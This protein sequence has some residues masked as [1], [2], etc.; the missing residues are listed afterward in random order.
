MMRTKQLVVSALAVL[1]VTAA[2]VGSA[3]PAIPT[4]SANAV[5]TVVA[6]TMQA[7]SALATPTSQP[8]TA[9]PPTATAT[10]AA[11]PP[12]PV[13]PSATRIN[14][15]ADATTGVVTA[16]IA[17]GQSQYYVLNAMQGQPMIAMVDSPNHDVTMSIKTAGGTSLLNGGQNLNMLLPV[18]EDYYFTIFGGASTENFTLNVQIP[19]RIKFAVGKTS[20]ILTGKTS[21][22][23][24][25]SYVLFASQNQKM[26]LNLNGV[27]G[28]AALAV[29]GFSDGQPYLRYV[30]ES[31]SFSMKLPSTQDYIIQV[32]PKAG[33]VVNY[34][35]VV[36]VQ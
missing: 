32:F 8:P 15:L 12:T 22:G 28:N 4:T 21:G 18:T 23:Y 26:N 31:T 34:T 35:L 17:P 13:L 25:V 20:A 1:L 36:N 6:A 10:V 5:A 29:Y 7:I 14:F 27:A 33:Q 16:P 11:L 19:A 9:P 2:C 24:V 30:T 3:S